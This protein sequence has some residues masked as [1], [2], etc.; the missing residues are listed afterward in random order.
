MSHGEGNHEN[1]RR[2]D[3]MTAGVE[4][5]WQQ[6]SGHQQPSLS[7]GGGQVG[8]DTQQPGS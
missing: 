5:G 2:S 8:D 4:A 6:A 7:I 3:R 1:L